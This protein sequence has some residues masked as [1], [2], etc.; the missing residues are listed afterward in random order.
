MHTAVPPEFSAQSQHSERPVTV[1]CRI[2]LQAT[3]LA[4][5]APKGNAQLEDYVPLSALRHSL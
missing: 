3:A 1:P 2:G 4:R 5:S